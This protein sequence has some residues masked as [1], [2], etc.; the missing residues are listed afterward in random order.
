M[1][2]YLGQFPIAADIL[3]PRLVG[4][5]TP[6][7]SDRNLRVDVTTRFEVDPYRP[8][9]EHV[10]M[11]MALAPDAGPGDVSHFDET[12]HGVVYFSQPDVSSMGGL[13][14]SR[15]PFQA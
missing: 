9:R 11:I 3:P 1:I 14:T 7:G 10:F 2:D 6:V 4:L 8:N 12:G 5:L 15:P 13:R